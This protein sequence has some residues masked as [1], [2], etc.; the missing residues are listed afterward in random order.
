MISKKEQTK[1]KKPLKEKV[2]AYSKCNKTFIP[3]NGW[4]KTHSWRC[5]IDYAQEIAAKNKLKVNRKALKEFK[6]GD[7][8]H[9]TKVAQQVFNK[10]IR[11]R[12]EHLPCISCN[13]EGNRQR[14]ASHFRPTGRNHQ[15]RFN[16][17]NCH[18]SCSI[19]NQHLSG[20]LVPY[21]V[22]LIEKIGLDRVEAL[23]A[24]NET[25]SYAVEEL[26]DII[27]TYKQKYKELV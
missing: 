3:Q 12:D 21:R 2:C 19:C 15:L 7:I 17:D 18:S 22:A 1:K 16:E 23:E 9:L 13:H 27:G 20:N 5:A 25:K 26:K 14:H 24:N 8:P 11:K 4:Q 6:D 10:Y